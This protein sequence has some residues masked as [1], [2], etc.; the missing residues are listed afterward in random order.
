MLHAA[1]HK[2]WILPPGSVGFVNRFNGDLRAVMTDTHPALVALR[3]I[4]RSP[5][6]VDAAMQP[7]Q[8]FADLRRLRDLPLLATMQPLSVAQPPPRLG[9]GL[10]GF[11]PCPIGDHRKALGA[12]VA[13]HHRP[14]YGLWIIALHLHCQGYI[15]A[16]RLATDRRR[17]DPPPHGSHVADRVICPRSARP[18]CRLEALRPND[19]TPKIPVPISA[20]P[21]L[22]RGVSPGQ[23]AGV[24]PPGGGRASQ[25]PPPFAIVTPGGDAARRT[26][27][28]IPASDTHAIATHACPHP[29]ARRRALRC[30]TVGR[31]F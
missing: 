13:A 6:A 7:S 11:Q 1:P 2:D 3:V 10:G 18:R 8:P 14:L 22:C 16:I 4:D 23:P 12:Q 5:L 29:E 17:K 9:Q 24:L 28:H 25:P 30:G 21:C 26:T 31:A 19:L 27:P 20:E 15:P